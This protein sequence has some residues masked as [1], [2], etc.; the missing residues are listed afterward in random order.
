MATTSSSIKKHKLITFHFC[1]PEKVKLKYFQINV[2]SPITY[3]TAKERSRHIYMIYLLSCYFTIQ[4]S[5]FGRRIFNSIL[6][7]EF[8]YFP[9]MGCFEGCN[10]CCSVF[11]DP[12]EQM[13]FTHNRGFSTVTQRQHKISVRSLGMK[14]TKER[15]YQY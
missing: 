10:M 8:L 11:L 5:Y 2:H 14:E 3:I 15:G 6:A 4:F 13:K 7:K 9:L 12:T 1:Q